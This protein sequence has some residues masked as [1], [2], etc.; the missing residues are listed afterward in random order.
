MISSRLILLDFIKK[1][2]E[3]IKLIL[4][5]TFHDFSS[6]GQHKIIAKITVKTIIPSNM[7]Y[8][9]TLVVVVV[10]VDTI[11]MPPHNFKL[12]ILFK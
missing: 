4:L 5:V 10:R 3:F 12:M 11:D 9:D 8:K 2:L 7:D 1:H 6:H